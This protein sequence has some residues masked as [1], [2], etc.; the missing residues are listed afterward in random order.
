MLELSL[1]SVRR[2]RIE[3]EAAEGDK[4]SQK[5]LPLITARQVPLSALQ[6]LKT[7]IGVFAAVYATLSF[8]EPLHQLLIKAGLSDHD[9]KLAPLLIV[10]V[11]TSY[12]LLVIGELLPTRIA[13]NSPERICRAFVSF[14]SAISTALYPLVRLLDFSSEF[15]STLVPTKKE[16]VTEGEIRNLIS[17][18][19]RIGVIEKGEEKI[20]SKVFRLGDKPANAIMTPRQEIEWL[21]VNDSLEKI[22]QEVAASEYTYFPL[23]D[24]SIENIIGIV[25][26]KDL[27]SFLLK[28]GSSDIRALAKEALRLPS[29]LTALQALEEFKKEGKQIAILIDEFGG[30][31]GLLTT[32]DLMEAMVGELSDNGME[33]PLFTQRPDGGYLVD[34]SIDLDEL[35]PL[36]SLPNFDHDDHKGYHSLGGFLLKKLGHLPKNGEKFEFSGHVF[37]VTSAQKNKV[38]KILIRKKGGKQR[39]A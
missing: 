1:V 29:S 17:K 28:G 39:A 36:L 10:I 35:F 15:L 19:S 24:G 31:D 30:I 18:G 25:S 4:K 33:E 11:L 21:D 34:A 26:T 22:W 12:F 9:H 37:E 3:A 6:A 27:S 16:D 7:L 20:V 14:I 38:D 2:S 8:S 5:I 23:A 13:L 32:H